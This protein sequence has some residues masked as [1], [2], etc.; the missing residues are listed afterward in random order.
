M[1]VCMYVHTCIYLVDFPIP[2][3]IEFGG[4]FPARPPAIEPPATPPAPPLGHS[5]CARC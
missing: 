2:I 3:A 5:N 1:Y 4:F